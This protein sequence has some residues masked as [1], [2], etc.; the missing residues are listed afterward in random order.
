[1]RARAAELAGRLG[2]TRLDPGRRGLLAVV[3]VAVLVAVV[4]GGWVLTSRPRPLP[5]TAT[6]LT[7]PVGPPGGSAV[8]GGAP[9]GSLA[10]P[11]TGA[12]PSTASSAP[13]GLVVDVAGK[14]RHP[15]VYRLP[16]GARVADAV[17]AAGGTLP[18]LDPVTVNLARKL[19]DGEQLLIGIVQPAPGPVDSAPD[20]AAAGGGGSTASAPSTGP[21]DLN[22]ATVA[23]L[24]G[25]PGVGPVLAQR[26][27]D[28]RAQHGRFDSV[29]QLNDVSGIGDAKFASLKPLVAV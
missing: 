23:Q 20:A 21:L 1:M 2:P 9:S 19:T 5:V 3:A 28:W 10:S 16:T 18:G 8:A 13:A 26:I 27:V 11:L 7:S 25:L 24:D 22:T 14:V 17:A 12:S 15:G 6:G 4:V 29:D